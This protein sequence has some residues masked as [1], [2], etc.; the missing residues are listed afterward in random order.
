VIRLEGYVKTPLTESTTLKIAENYRYIEEGRFNYYRHTELEFGWIF[1]KNWS[2]APAAR[3]IRARAQH[4]D[5]KESPMWIVNLNQSAR[6]SALDLKTRLRLTYLS[7][8]EVSDRTDFRP[9][10]TLLPRKG[11][12]SWKLKPYIADELLYNFQDNT[13]YRNRLSGGLKLRPAKPLAIDLFIMQESTRIDK[14]NDWEERFNFGL[15]AA[16]LL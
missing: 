6:L 13:L 14:D 5:W 2:L 15:S 7:A 12:T 10:F 16:V 9:K 11:W 8:D 3:Y 1:A 4:S